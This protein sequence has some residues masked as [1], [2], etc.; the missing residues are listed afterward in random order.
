ME[1]SEK[2]SISLWILGWGLQGP[3]VFLMIVVCMDPQIIV[4]MMM[5]GKTIQPCE[6]RSD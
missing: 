5:G 1:I 4:V 2:G 6:I 3:S